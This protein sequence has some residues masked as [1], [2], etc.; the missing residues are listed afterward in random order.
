MINGVVVDEGCHD[1]FDRGE[2]TECESE[3]GPPV[4]WCDDTLGTEC[5]IDHRTEL[6]MAGGI[7]NSAGKTVREMAPSPGITW[8]V[9]DCSGFVVERVFTSEATDRVR[10]RTSSLA[11]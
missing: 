5:G 7:T 3:A 4:W 9:Q 6:S 11:L 10:S 8:F 2:S 1:S